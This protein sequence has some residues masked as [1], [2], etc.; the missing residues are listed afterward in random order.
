MSKIAVRKGGLVVKNTKSLWL[1]VLWLW[2]IWASRANH[3]LQLPVF[4]DES[5]HILRAQMVFEFNDAT[6][7]ILP[8]KL[9]LYYYLG[10]FDLQD[11]GGAW[12]ARQAVGLL[13]PLTVAL[14]VALTRLLTKHKSAA[15]WVWRLYLVSPFL[16]F[17]E[18]MALADTFTMLWGLALA[19]AVLHF[20]R[21]PS[22]NLAV[23]TGLLLGLSVLTKLTALPWLALPLIGSWLWRKDQPLPHQQLLQIYSVFALCL[24][25]PLGY[26]VYQ[27]LGT[28]EEK[29]EVVTTTLYVSE[30]SSQ[31]EQWLN[32]LDHYQEA[33]RQMLTLPL[34]ILLIVAIFWQLKYKWRRA[35]YLL[36][37]TLLVWGFVTLTSARPSTRYLVVGVPPLLI[38]VSISLADWSFYSK[39]NKSLKWLDWSGFTLASW[40]ILAG[41]LFMFGVWYAPERL[42]LTERDTW[43]YY[44]NAASGYALNSAAEDL[45]NL[46]PIQGDKVPV[47]GFVA[48]CHTL[49]LYLPADHHVELDCPYFKWREEFAEATLTEWTAR[50]EE[51][52]AYYILA[53][54]TQPLDIFQLPFEFQEI[55]VYERPHNGTR[56]I[57]YYVTISE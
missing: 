18:R 19:I 8:G 39:Q 55:K 40:V 33:T 51:N 26:I 10:F 23:I 48:A 31:V 45:P 29:Q 6:A 15:N 37:I 53:D 42:I 12:L 21:R 1:T 38:L 44:Q 28:V 17:F 16:L 50:I 13:V 54:E 11:V 56:T 36:S 49:R 4:V 3:I 27:E 14:T 20:A 24:L 2:L 41:I 22:Q 35:V 52:G 43:E 47:G 32:N 5:L 25:L 30:E 34:T 57:L 7:S 9:L 46:E